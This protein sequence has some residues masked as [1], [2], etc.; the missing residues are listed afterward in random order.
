MADSGSQGSGRQ[1][2][3]I[4]AW[5]EENER[6]LDTQFSITTYDSKDIALLLR[7]FQDPLSADSGLEL[8]SMTTHATSLL[9]RVSE[10]L[11]GH[12]EQLVR[13][14]QQLL[15]AT[16]NFLRRGD[17]GAARQGEEVVKLVEQSGVAC[18]TEVLDGVLG[19]L[20]EGVSS[21]QE[22]ATR[23]CW[24]EGLLAL[25]RGEVDREVVEALGEEYLNDLNRLVEVLL[26]CGDYACQAALLE[27]V[28]R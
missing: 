15:E 10:D 24:L 12:E 4:K 28:T 19:W 26:S 23:R 14:L 16:L 6:L 11:T 13:L 18:A 20:L 9:L 2:R 21:G 17:E 5:V 27:V 8:V 1:L 22:L 3:R 25:L 7:T